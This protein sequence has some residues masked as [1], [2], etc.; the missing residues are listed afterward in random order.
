MTNWQLGAGDCKYSGLPDNNDL[1]ND[2]FCS[3]IITD[4]KKAK[5]I[6]S[7]ESR[8]RAYTSSEL[9]RLGWNTKHPNSGGNILEEQEAKN[10]DE[11]FNEL[12]GKDRPDFLIYKDSLP[13]GIIECK[14]EKAKIESA[15]DQSIGY[16][17]KLSKKYFNVRIAIG[18]SGNEEDGVVVRSLYKLD[19]GEWEEIK[20]NGYPLTQLLSEKQL[21]QVLL[22][23]KASIDLEIP[24]ESEFY[25]VAEKINKIMHEA[26]V[27]KSDRAVYLASIILAMQE[28]DVDTRPNV[29]L[30]QINANVE[31][32]LRKKNKSSLKHIFAINGNKQKLRKQLPLIFH[33]L[34]RLNIRALMNS[35]ADI[36]GKFYE[37]FWITRKN[38]CLAHA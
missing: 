8:A 6:T 37:T 30:E 7:A 25:E 12:L 9:K 21:E 13:I 35:G 32:A 19:N 5:K 4:F 17:D 24:T 34:D 29:I 14:N 38:M 22:N 28:G 11:R 27:N 3:V 20:G 18:V 2:L 26:K 15:I 33:N 1:K 31:S 23:K 16:A 10:Y 36:L